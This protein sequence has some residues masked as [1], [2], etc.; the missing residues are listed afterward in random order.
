[1]AWC[2][3]PASIQWE[4]FIDVLEPVVPFVVES[5]M[6]IKEHE[7]IGSKLRVSMVV[8]AAVAAPLPGH[9]DLAGVGGGGQPRLGS[10]WG[11]TFRST[12]GRGTE[13]GKSGNGGGN[14]KSSFKCR[15]VCVCGRIPRL[16]TWSGIEQS[17]TPG[18]PAV[19]SAPDAT[20]P[21]AYRG[22]GW[23]RFQCWGSKPRALGLSLSKLG[24]LHR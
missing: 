21:W 12:N 8:T 17:W 18:L 16:L 22:L 4:T 15:A 14:S 13:W 20:L 3:H 7:I 1:M 10:G 2:L 19:V 24:R 11:P 5:P 6:F 9:G 23:A